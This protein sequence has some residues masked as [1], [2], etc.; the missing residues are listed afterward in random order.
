[1]CLEGLDLLAQCY[2][3]DLEFLASLEGFLRLVKAD[4][5]AVSQQYRC[6][7]PLLGIH[8]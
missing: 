1:M 6:Y 4:V 7:C 3:L 2:V 5:E 8:V